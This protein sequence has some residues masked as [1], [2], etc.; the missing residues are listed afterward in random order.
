[1]MSQISYYTPE[2]RRAF[3]SVTPP[4]NFYVDVVEHSDDK[5]LFFIDIMFDKKLLLEAS[6]DEKMDIYRYLQTVKNAL[7]S[8]GA[9]VQVT[10]RAAKPR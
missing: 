9:I 7:E 1:M 3:H 5:Q 6:H 8:V 2:M 10:G 4:K